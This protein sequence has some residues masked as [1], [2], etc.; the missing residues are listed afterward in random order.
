[1]VKMSAIFSII[2]IASLCF[3]NE[4]ESYS[5]G[6]I[7]WVVCKSMIPGHSTQSQPTSTSIYGI[8]FDSNLFIP[9]HP[10][11]VHL[12]GLPEN[13]LGFYCQSR[14][15][16]NDSV[17]V[18]HFI[19]IEALDNVRGHDCFNASLPSMPG[20]HTT[21][22]HS[23]AW[24]R[25]PSLHL[26]LDWMTTDDDLEKFKIRCTFVQ[27]R[28]V[29]WVGIESRF[30]TSLPNKSAEDC[31]EADHVYDN[32]EPL[33][34][35]ASEPPDSFD[36]AKKIL[37]GSNET[38][39]NFKKAL[40]AIRCSYWSK[41]D[42]ENDTEYDQK[43]IENCCFRIGISLRCATYCISKT[44]ASMNV[45][46]A[47]FQDCIRENP[48]LS[49]CI[50]HPAFD[51]IQTT[52]GGESDVTMDATTMGLAAHTSSA[53]V[54][55][56]SNK[57][58]ASPV[59]QTTTYTPQP[60]GTTIFRITITVEVEG[61]LEDTVLRQ[62]IFNAL[63]TDL[64]T[65]G[66]ANVNGYRGVTVG[67]EVYEG[68]LVVVS[69][70]RFLQEDDGS[71]PL[72]SVVKNALNERLNENGDR[73]R[74]QSQHWSVFTPIEVNRKVINGLCESNSCKSDEICVEVGSAD[75]VCVCL[76]QNQKEIQCQKS[77]N[78][79]LSAGG[80]AGIVVG[81]LLFL[82]IIVFVIVYACRQ[83]TT[84]DSSKPNSTNTIKQR[85]VSTNVEP[86]YMYISNEDI[87]PPALPANNRATLPSHSMTYDV[88]SSDEG[89]K[90][91]NELKENEE[92]YLVPISS[93]IATV[94]EDKS[95]ETEPDKSNKNLYSEAY[96]MYDKNKDV[97]LMNST[98]ITEEKEQINK[99]LKSEADTDD[100][101]SVHS[102]YM[103][104]DDYEL[105]DNL[106]RSLPGEDESKVSIKMKGN[107][108]YDE[109]NE[110]DYLEFNG[111][112]DTRI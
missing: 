51:N 13:I 19:N 89:N 39:C 86:L 70:S 61:A 87:K 8:Y 91:T 107:K 36:E 16:G 56:S 73:I 26:A 38:S 82:L 15:P 18:G 65:P 63:Q 109:Y 9:H 45:D 67:V 81:C 80:I 79:G 2:C 110:S 78:T 71:V 23:W 33:C 108:D 111:D 43:E 37:Q 102:N 58:P 76:D 49:S 12:S 72:L 75:F 25:N 1:M 59:P 99:E 68:S 101:S 69:E 96:S 31:C 88:P 55:P 48:Q 30:V 34:R 95:S 44:Y 60:T 103:S 97:N 50:I 84:R 112:Q 17:P 40:L 62:N 57:S 27:T 64:L 22:S 4:V 24:T 46:E 42:D 98:D 92:G 94:P 106:G 104:L 32:C 74:H 41:F 77:H 90:S 20:S 29:F 105:A 47:E 85:H 11:K 14:N 28:T 6:D 54:T 66:L 35:H 83:K 3:I 93:D 52:L 21:V 5:N 7:P 10:I 53:A 100:S